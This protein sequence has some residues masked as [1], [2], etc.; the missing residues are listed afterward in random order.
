MY[1][2][3]LQ[4]ISFAVISCV[5]QINKTKISVLIIIYISINKISIK[6]HLLDHKQLVCI[7]C[8]LRLFCFCYTVIASHF[9]SIINLNYL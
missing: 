3:I 2:H 9:V 4:I 8:I 7:K 6:A 5:L 1:L